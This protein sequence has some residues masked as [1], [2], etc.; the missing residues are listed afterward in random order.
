MPVTYIMLDVN[1]TSIKTKQKKNQSN[2]SKLSRARNKGQN[3][4]SYRNVT[5]VKNAQNILRL[6]ENVFKI[7]DLVKVRG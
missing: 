2:K 5:V 4:Y 7:P 3:I 6:Q 1:Y